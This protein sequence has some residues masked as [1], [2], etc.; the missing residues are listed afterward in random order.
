MLKFGI[1]GG[2]I[3][4]HAPQMLSLPPTEDAEQVSRVRQAMFEIG[5]GLRALEPDLVIV[6]SNDHG[7][8]YVLH[9][10][11]PFVVHCGDAADGK[12]KHAGRWQLAGEVGYDVLQALYEEGF[13]PAFSLTAPVATCFT[14]PY[15][16]MGYGRDAPFLP[17]FVN[18]YVPPQPPT[19]RCFAFGRAL[20]RALSRLGKRA[21]LIASGGLSHYPGTARYAS[22]GPDTSTD[23]RIFG[24]WTEGRL[25]SI[26]SFGGSALDGSGN[27]EARS[28][29]VLAGAIGDRKPTHLLFEP[30]WHH[31]YGVL[32]WTDD[33]AAAESP[34]YYARTP[35]KRAELARAV[36]AL[37][38]QDSAVA[39]YAA[40]REAFARQY[41]LS[42]DEQVAL[43]R[44]DEA[45]LRDQYGIH[46]LLTSAAHYRVNA[47]LK[48][49]AQG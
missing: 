1:V 5:E 39:A 17:V 36:H 49:A 44:L 18:S 4:P 46:P 34:L 23:S 15:E 19:E 13:D 28:M 45:E 42:D 31:N 12:G 29:L 26:L 40:D 2:A 7:D 8:E 25:R 32:G 38:M 35:S 24:D 47:K 37:R 27:V 48:A 6:L 22:P 14:I 9:S 21:V 41:K 3:V 30:N 11:P 33:G 16:F 20:H 10:V 43:L